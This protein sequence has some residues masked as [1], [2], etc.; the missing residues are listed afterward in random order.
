MF[1]L[2]SGALRAEETSKDFVVGGFVFT[3][4]KKWE[5][6]KTSSPMRKAEFKVLE[7]K[8]QAVA[9]VVFFYFG[10]GQG[11]SAAENVARWK[12]QVKDLTKEKVEEREVGGTKVTLVKFEGSYQSGMPGGPKVPQAGAALWGAVLEG[13]QGN[14]FVRLTGPKDWVEKIGNEFD[15][16]IESGAK[17]K[18]SN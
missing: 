5:M 14:V 15:A 7:D 12:S 9:E 2:F 1:V 18:R 17:N 10:P 3:A 4:P 6:Q 13:A 11:G 16:M 8:T